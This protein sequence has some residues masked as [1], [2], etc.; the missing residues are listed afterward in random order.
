MGTQFSY[1]CPHCLT[2]GAGFQARFHWQP[3][4]GARHGSTLATCGICRG[5]LTLLSYAL[6]SNAHIDIVQHEVGFPGNAFEILETWPR[7]TGE[8]PANV[9]S[10]V[11]SFYNQGLENIG[12]GHWDAAG[13]MFRK[14]LDVA[15][16]T[17]APDKRSKR[18]YD[19]ITELV[20]D[21]RLTAP[22]GEWAHEIR[23]DG[24]DS[25]HDDEPES[26]Q[27]A[28]IMHRYTEALLTY[29]FTL[30]AMDEANRAKRQP[31]NDA[32]SGSAA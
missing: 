9:P 10:N 11:R 4:L 1:D 30:P 14:S 13:A 7:F 8:C 32:A 12:N 22:M 31:A 2:R 16:K 3:L 24:N 29:T 15:T 5:G 23:L 18:L 21:G 17:L 28:K 26:E 19:R 6:N 20:T 25:V 27:D